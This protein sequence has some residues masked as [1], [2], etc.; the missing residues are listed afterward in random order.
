MLT[1]RIRE[2]LADTPDVTEK[3]MFGGTAFMVDGKLCITVGDRDIMCR[4]DP[5]IQHELVEKKGCSAMVMKGR[6]LK[7]YVL[8]SEDSVNNKSELMYWVNLCLAFNKFA[9]SSKK[10][11]K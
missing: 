11:K 3:N 6:K 8:V 1:N 7:G 10:K 2:A 5:A 9:K 4:I